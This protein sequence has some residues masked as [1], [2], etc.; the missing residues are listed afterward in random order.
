ML[1]ELIARAHTHMHRE[2]ED[3][4]MTVSPNIVSPTSDADPASTT[5]EE[6]PV[7][8]SVAAVG[9]AVGG[10]IVAILL[11]MVACVMLLM[12]RKRRKQRDQ[13]AIDNAIYEGIIIVFYHG[14]KIIGVG[15]L[16]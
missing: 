8:V 16:L 7:G 12:L 2:T 10:V 11:A 5:T 1:H 9:G 13:H 4:D 6:P 14:A 15:F 3:G